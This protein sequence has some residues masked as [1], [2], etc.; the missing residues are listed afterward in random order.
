[1]VVLFGLVVLFR[2]P[3]RIRYWGYQLAH[4]TSATDRDYYF[5]LL[6]SRNERS[7][8][9]AR[10]LLASGDVQTRLD[11]VD[12]A[13]T[14]KS[15]AATALLA[16]ACDD[17][18]A[19]VRR[20]AIIALARRDD[21]GIVGRLR[22]LADHTDVDTAMLATS[23]LTTVGSP[24]ALETLIQLAHA[25]HRAG[26]RAQAIESLS[27]WG[28]EPGVR[29]ALEACLNDDVL[30]EFPIETERQARAALAFAQGKLAER[31]EPITLDDTDPFTPMT[32]AQRAA[33]ALDRLNVS[34]PTSAPAP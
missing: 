24:R 13:T 33:R 20:R 1:M 15:R 19:A 28:P 16:R 14:V 26:V 4:S 29:T 22:T 27:Q 18:D 17:P 8:P 5:Q 25:N 3:I 32:N 6:A 23:A 31:G 2:E 7:L 12:L 10:R 9:I 11:A 30:V 34:I 21:D